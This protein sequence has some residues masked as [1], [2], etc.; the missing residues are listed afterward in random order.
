MQARSE[1][2]CQGHVHVQPPAPP[3]SSIHPSF[4]EQPRCGSRHDGTAPSRT[5]RPPPS[6][7]APSRAQEQPPEAGGPADVQATDS[8]ATSSST[9]LVHL[10]AEQR[11]LPHQRLIWRHVQHPQH[12]EQD[13][14]ADVALRRCVAVRSSSQ[15]SGGA[16]SKAQ[17]LLP[18]S[19]SK[20]DQLQPLRHHN[21]L[22]HLA[23]VWAG[24]AGLPA[25]GHC[26]SCRDGAQMGS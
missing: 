8:S 3:L 22:P 9:R 10:R 26:V 6:T 16:S 4:L 14:L 17:S 2:E 15:W 13:V 11:L 7:A 1:A 21:L 19:A 12:D 24:A 25:D 18:S 5:P 20:G 23:S